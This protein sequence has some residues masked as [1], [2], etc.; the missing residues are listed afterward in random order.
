MYLK[1]TKSSIEKTM[2]RVNNVSILDIG[3][4]KVTFLGL[5]VI[6]QIKQSK[7]QIVEQKLN[8]FITFV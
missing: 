8:I 3:L 4:S 1:Q 6:R 7:M 2:K 5:G